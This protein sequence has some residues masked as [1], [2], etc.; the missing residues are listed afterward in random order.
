MK[1]HLSF[2]TIVATTFSIILLS[3]L[4]RILKRKRSTRGKIQRPPQAK[5]ALPIIGHLHL[6]SG[7][8]LPH[9]VLGNMAEKHGP[10]FS[11]KLGLQDAVVVS[12]GTIAKSCFTT[13]DKAFATRPKLEAT[14]LLAYNY[15][16]FGF[17][18]HGEYWRQMRKMFKSEVL[19]QKRVE[20]F[21]HVRGSELKESIK[22]LYNEM[23][24]NS[25]MVKV[26]MDQWFGN[27][28]VNIMVRVIIGKRYS[29]ND[30]EGV[31]FQTIVKKFFEL[32]GAFVVSDFIPHL[33]CL[34]V[35]GYV[36]AMKKT[37]LD[38][39]NI[40]EGWLKEQKKK[41]SNSNSKAFGANSVWQQ[42]LVAGLNTTSGTLTWALALLLNNPNALKKAQDEIDEHVGRVRLVEESDLKNLVYL[43]AIIKETLRLYPATPLLVPRESME[44]CIVGDYNIPKGTRLLV[45][46]Y[47]MHRDPNIWEDPLEFSP[48]RFLIGKHI[49]FK[50]KHYELLPFG[51]GRRMCP[52]IQFSI[53]AVSLTLASLIQQF[54]LKKSSDEPIDMSESYGLTICK[55][56][57]LEVLLAPRLSSNMY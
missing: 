7:P 47:K 17:S 2:A 54:V 41:K 1:F 33:K 21:G 18:P 35:G 5:G 19:S 57:P 11:I 56:T 6:L 12:N 44:D 10:I 45:N 40:F 8:Q 48:E 36:K 13:N 32:M 16:V 38:L 51:S 49:D 52:G 31:R 53:P 43:D 4:L 46:L 37:A 50:G 28:V 20:M 42:L 30:E 39:D 55:T 29:Q 22:D 26:E 23:S 34:D 27:L 14:K 9:H 24:P 15:A 3:F 25:E